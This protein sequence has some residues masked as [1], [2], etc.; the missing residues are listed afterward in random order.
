MVTM[1][2]TKAREE[3]FPLLG[4]VNQDRDIV[5]ITSKAGNGV[6]MSED[7]YDEMETILHLYSTPANAKRLNDSL[8][9]AARNE[10]IRVNPDTFEIE[11]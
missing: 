1:T 11:S 3:L 8:E 5:R 4:K 6:L 10:V 2:A 9:R 7:D